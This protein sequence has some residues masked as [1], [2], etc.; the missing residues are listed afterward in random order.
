MVKQQSGFT[1]IE[2]IAVIV[3]LG[4][5]AAT[6]VP[7]FVDLSDAAET[8]TARNI[9]GSIE[10]ASA[11]NHAVDIAKEANLTNEDMVEIETCRDAIGLLV[12]GLPT[13]YDISPDTA[14]ADKASVECQLT[15][16]SNS[17]PFNVIGAVE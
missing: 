17:Y 3:I 7:K 13:G 4:I 10:S 6:A 11:L 5:L 9:A 8:A 1:L 14:V 2:L 12:N 16:N 15:L